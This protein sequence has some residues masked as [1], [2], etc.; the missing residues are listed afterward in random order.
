MI[1]WLILYAIVK[2]HYVHGAWTGCF[3]YVYT[4]CIKKPLVVSIV[5]PR[6]PEQYWSGFT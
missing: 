1:G 3:Y 4:V 6:E 5:L 2:A